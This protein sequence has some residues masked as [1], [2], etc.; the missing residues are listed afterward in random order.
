[1]KYLRLVTEKVDKKVRDGLPQRFG[2]IMDGWTS[3]TSLH[4]CV[5]FACIPQNDD[6]VDETSRPMLA[7]SPLL[8]ETSQSSANHAEWI[9]ATLALYG[10]D[11]DSL[12]FFMSDNTNAMPLTAQLLM[13]P[14]LGCAAH[15]LALFVKLYLDV[16]PADSEDNPVHVVN[17][18]KRLMKKLRTANKSGALQ[19]ET[20]LKP[21]LSNATRWSST[22][23]MVERYLMILDCIDCNDPQ[24]FPL[25]LSPLENARVK[26]MTRVMKMMNDVT[27]LLQGDAINHHTSRV[28]LDGV[29]A[30]NIGVSPDLHISKTANIIREPSFENGLAKLAAGYHHDILTDDEKVALHR[31]LKADDGD[32]NDGKEDEE[33]STTGNFAVDLLRANKRQRR[34]TASPYLMQSLFRLH[35]F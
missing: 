8:D 7:F 30:L 9:E 22:F 15:R 28:L 3:S 29:I 17:K 5:L 31:F 25:M 12:L 11:R 27:V 4:F 26:E 10:K 1:M 6:V 19:M 33:V 34:A 21:L 13:C 14:F 23:C 20:H 16:D 24:L 2:L 32:S 35:L 18:V